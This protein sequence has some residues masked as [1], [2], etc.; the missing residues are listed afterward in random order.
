M[1]TQYTTLV[2]VHARTNLLQSVACITVEYVTGVSQKE[3]KAKCEAKRNKGNNAILLAG[4]SLV[5]ESFD[6]LL[7]IETIVLCVS[8]VKYAGMVKA[9]QSKFA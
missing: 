4:I 6:I 2:Q 7:E 3:K 5:V 8:K 1:H 9:T